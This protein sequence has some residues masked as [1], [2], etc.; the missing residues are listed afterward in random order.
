MKA[1]V[2]EETNKIDAIMKVTANKFKDLEWKTKLQKRDE[3]QMINNNV[4]Y[5]IDSLVIK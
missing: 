1:N 3:Q 5:N 4:T 2:R